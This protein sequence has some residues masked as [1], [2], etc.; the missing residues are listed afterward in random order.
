MSLFV[1][2]IAYSVSIFLFIGAIVA[3]VR[4]WVGVLG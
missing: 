3:A 2:I 4:F 1:E